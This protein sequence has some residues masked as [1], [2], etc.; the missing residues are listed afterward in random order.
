MRI[1][2]VFQIQSMWSDCA[3]WQ[4]TAKKSKNISEKVDVYLNYMAVHQSE[5]H[6]KTQPAEL[7]LSKQLTYLYIDAEDKNH[8]T[9][10]N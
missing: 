9:S 6:K 4:K 1:L 8:K 5:L 10:A 3:F 7:S 2:A